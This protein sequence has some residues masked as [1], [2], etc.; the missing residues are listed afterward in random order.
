METVF[1]VSKKII[2]LEKELSNLLKADIQGDIFAI[3]NGDDLDSFIKERKEKINWLNLREVIGGDNKNV[4]EIRKE[5]NILRERKLMLSK[6][7][8]TIKREYSNEIPTMYEDV[9]DEII[10]AYDKR[11]EELFSLEVAENIRI[12]KKE[13]ENNE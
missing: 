13:E 2:K 12:T 4:E 9:M 3:V 6:H 11:I 8:K 10:R 7:F 1:K 5:I